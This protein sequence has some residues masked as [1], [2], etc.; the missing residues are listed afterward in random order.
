[1]FLTTGPHYCL[2]CPTVNH[3]GRCIGQKLQLIE[4][5]YSGCDVD[6]VQCPQCKDIF[7]IS[8]KVDKIVDITIKYGQ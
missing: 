6:M 3:K 2:A 1:M 4:R 5:N 7:E 8:Y